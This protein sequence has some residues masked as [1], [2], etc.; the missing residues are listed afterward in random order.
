MSDTAQDTCTVT[1]ERVFPHPPAKLWRAL[2]EDALL[3][4]WLLKNN[5]EP[6]VGH[7]FQFRN[8]P[9]PQWDGVIDCEVRIVDPGRQLSYTWQ[10]LGVDTV[11]LWTL[12]LVEGGTRLRVEQSGFPAENTR[13]IGGANYGWQRFLGAL[14]GVLERAQ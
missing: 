14:E 7:R 12:T 2:T 6:R 5:F 1:I 13:A 11:V 9:M 8:E 4:E 3:A 10:A